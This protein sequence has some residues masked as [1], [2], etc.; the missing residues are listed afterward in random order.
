MQLNL[1]SLKYKEKASLN[2]GEIDWRKICQDDEQRKLF[3]KYLLELTTQEMTYDNFCEAVVRAGQKTAV[4]IE[5]KCE[6]WHTASEAILAPAIEEKI[7][8]HHVCRKR[9]ISPPWKSI[10]SNNNYNI[11]TSTRTLILSTWP[12]HADTVEYAPTYKT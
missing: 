7:R 8:L 10:N 1:T 4:S 5:H 3:N 6:G 2:N 9:T 12:K 11:S